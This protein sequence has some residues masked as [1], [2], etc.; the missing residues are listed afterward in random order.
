MTLNNK[1]L[2]LIWALYLTTV[3][4]SC[5]PPAQSDDPENSIPD[6]LI[7]VTRF[8]PKA[9]MLSFGAEAITGIET[10]KGI[11]II[12]AGMATGLTARYRSLIEKEFHRK[13]FVV[14]F[15]THGHHDHYGENS[16]FGEARIVAHQN[17]TQAMEGRWLNPEKVKSN[18]LRV[19]GE[20]SSALDTISKNHE[21]WIE[22]FKLRIRVQEAYNDI[23]NDRPARLPD[24]TFD[25]SLRIEM[26]DVTFDLIWFGKGHSWSDILIHVPELK[27]LFTGDLFSGYGRPSIYDNSVIDTIRLA[28]VRAWTDVRMKETEILIGGHGQLM[29]KE[30]LQS[31][32]RKIRAHIH[33]MGI[34]QKV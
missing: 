33:F 21:D 31:F 6:S 26:D 14:L 5:N 28:R 29:T 27:M 11:A 25:D 2:K 19:I 30:D 12:D 34:N 7:Q 17:C 3:L 9:I 24:T 10:K 15:I 8:N 22:N 13:D 23:I 32:Y 20:Y 1:I 4:T 18:L 16:V